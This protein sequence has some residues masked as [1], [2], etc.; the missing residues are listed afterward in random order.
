MLSFRHEILVDLFRGNG[1]LAAELLRTC[2]G[3]VVNHARVVLD[4]IDLSQVA[5]TAYYAD[6]VAILRD[7]DDRPLTGVIVEVQLRDDQDKLLSWPVYV[8]TLRAKLACAA[9]LLVIAPDPSVA[10]WARQPIELG[11]PGVHLTPIVIGFEDVSWVRDRVIASRVPELAMFS[12][13]WTCSDPDEL[14]RLWPLR[15]ERPRGVSFRHR[16]DAGPAMSIARSASQPS[17][18]SRSLELEHVV[19]ACRA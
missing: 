9:V 8:N 10:A 2:A 12:V 18:C 11:H 16:R 13:R 1:Q 15:A 17:R 4:S 19:S 5:P 7:G 6:A 14:A 3:S